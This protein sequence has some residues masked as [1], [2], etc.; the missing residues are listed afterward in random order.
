MAY[1]EENK[2]EAYDKFEDLVNMSASEIE[3]WLKT[4]ESKAVGQDSGDGESI[5]RKSA[6]HIVQILK[7]KKQDLNE[8]DFH[9]IHKVISYISRHS[10]QRPHGDVSKTDW[11]YS[12]KN[13]GHDPQ[14]K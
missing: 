4:D 12:L 13:W 11:L 7:M 5:G 8:D 6:K 1:S 10:A 3:K 9:H 2:K 14:K